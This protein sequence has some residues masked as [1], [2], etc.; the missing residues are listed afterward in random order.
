[1]SWNIHGHVAIKLQDPDL[2]ACE[3]SKD[4]LLL[5]ETWLRAGD[6]EALP[7]PSGLDIV[8]CPSPSP[9]STRQAW[10]GLAIIF[11]TGLRAQV[12]RE[13]STEFI[14][15]VHI[16]G[17]FILNCYLP[18]EA[19]PFLPGMMNGFFEDFRHALAF[20]KSVPGMRIA[21]GGD[22]NSRIG[23]ETPSPHAA[24]SILSLLVHRQI[25]QRTLGDVHY[26]GSALTTICSL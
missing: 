15:V 7:L 20:C 24:Y 13:V 21:T 25:R 18:P 11:R 19:S 17:L 9:A 26:C 2:S 22:L 8:A 12:V 5:Q 6:D 23:S 16:H 3:F 10:G 1:M 4:I 14:L